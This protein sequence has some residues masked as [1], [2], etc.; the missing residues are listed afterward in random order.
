MHVPTGAGRSATGFGRGTDPTIHGHKA[1]AGLHHAPGQEQVLAERMHA[2]ALTE[3]EWFL[4]QIK[5]LAAFRPGHRV[6]GQFAEFAPVFG[7]RIGPEAIGFE[8]VEQLAPL[9]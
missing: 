9:L 4:I 3:N 7:Q 1:D 6:V 8:D 5:G 2:V